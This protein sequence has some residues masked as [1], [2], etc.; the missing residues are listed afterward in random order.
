MSTY[1]FN[2]IGVVEVSFYTSAVIILD[3]MLKASEVTLVSCEKTL[4]GR[5]VSIIV[6]GDTSSVNASVEVAEQLGKVVGEKNIKVA[7]SI[8]NPHPEIIKLLNLINKPDQLQ[9]KKQEISKA[10]DETIIKA[11]PNKGRNK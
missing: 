11:K 3:E 2:A 6:G 8:L 1:E 7:V 5:L 10:Q 4:G 9:G